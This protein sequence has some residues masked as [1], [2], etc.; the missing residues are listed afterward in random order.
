MTAVDLPANCGWRN[1]DDISSK[2]LTR[3]RPSLIGKIMGQIITSK[4]MKLLKID[5]MVKESRV[6]HS[7]QSNS[8]GHLTEEEKHLAS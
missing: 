4:C 2:I 7:K 1:T 5:K 3:I 8:L 6:N